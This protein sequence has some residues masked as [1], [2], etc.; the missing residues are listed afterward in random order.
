MFHVKHIYASISDNIV[1][2]V[3]QQF[4]WKIQM[5]RLLRCSIE[6]GANWHEVEK[7]A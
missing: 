6:M 7:A 3:A 2:N 4:G 1:A 5:L